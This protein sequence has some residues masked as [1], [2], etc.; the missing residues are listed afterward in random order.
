MATVAFAKTPPFWFPAAVSLVAGQREQDG[1]GLGST[2]WV[3]SVATAAPSEGG[4]ERVFLSLRFLPFHCEGSHLVED[5]GRW[6]MYGRAR[7]CVLFR[8]I[9]TWHGRGKGRLMREEGC[10]QSCNTA[11]CQG[12]FVSYLCLYYFHIVLFCRLSIFLLS[13]TLFTSSRS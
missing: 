9:E 10:V 13:L 12:S 4:G 6:V 7:V 11:S 2:A 5:P 8:M 3:V 1:E